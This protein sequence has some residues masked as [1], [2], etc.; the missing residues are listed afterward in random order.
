MFNRVI[1]QVFLLGFPSLLFAGGP[2]AEITA[3]VNGVQVGDDYITF[4][5]YGDARLF[6]LKT[7]QE[8][9][10]TMTE[11][12]AKWVSLRF[13]NRFLVVHRPK[14]PVPGFSDN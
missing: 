3:H 5:V 11:G 4:A 1:L 7:E 14:E 8:H 9:K 10:Q 6:V 2:D 12:N 13:E